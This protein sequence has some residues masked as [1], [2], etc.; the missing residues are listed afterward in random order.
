MQSAM[1]H[2]WFASGLA[3]ASLVAIALAFGGERRPHSRPSAAIA[4]SEPCEPLDLP[5]EPIESFEPPREDGAD[6]ELQDPDLEPLLE[7][8]D[9]VE[10]D[11]LP[12]PLVERTLPRTAAWYERIKPP[13]REPLPP[14]PLPEAAAPQPRVVEAIEGENPPP[15]YPALAQRRG[16]EGTVELEVAVAP[17]GA[18]AACTVRRSCGYPILD[19]QAV[20]A[21]RR[22]RFRGGPGT[23]VVP[24]EFRL[25]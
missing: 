9:D 17:D 12:G 6:V 11:P 10:S 19:H 8:I 14:A 3:H 7:R 21:V 20:H 23:I 13:P 2:A 25:R 1:R 15:A 5:A 4:I 18:V 24:I 22:W 16:W